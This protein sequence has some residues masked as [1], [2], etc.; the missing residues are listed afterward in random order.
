MLTLVEHFNV[1][2]ALHPAADAAG[3]TSRYVSLKNAHRAWIVVHLD[4]GNAATVALT[5]KQATAVAGTGSKVLTAAARI[6]ANEDEAA[7][8]ALARQADATS[9]TTSAALKH[10][11]VVFEIEP[12]AMLDLAGG[13]DCIAITTGASHAANITEASFYLE[14]RYPAAALPSAIVD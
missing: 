7:A 9:F 4:Q 1:V 13:F 8:D 14:S 11:R 12:A 3:R 6:W 2:E 5:P 10:K